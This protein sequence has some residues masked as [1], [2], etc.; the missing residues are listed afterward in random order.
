MKQRIQEY[1]DKHTKRCPGCGKKR[2]IHPL[3]TKCI[4]CEM[5]KSD[6]EIELL[7]EMYAENIDDEE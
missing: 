2:F 3:D 1:K 7:V 5:N 4:R 6:F